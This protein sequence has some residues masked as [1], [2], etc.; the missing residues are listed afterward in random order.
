MFESRRRAINFT[1]NGHRRL[2]GTLASHWGNRDFESPELP[3][4]SFHAGVALHDLGVGTCDEFAIGAMSAS[5]RAFTLW[6][7]M[8]TRA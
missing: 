1:Q 6:M 2:A 4:E 7:K 8:S 5:E 3:T